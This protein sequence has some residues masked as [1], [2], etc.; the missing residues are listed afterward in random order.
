M[1]DLTKGRSFEGLCFSLMLL[2]GSPAFTD[3]RG[4]A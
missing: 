4:A 1:G 3:I 2:Q